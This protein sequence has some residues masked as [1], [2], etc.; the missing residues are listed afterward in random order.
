[1]SKEK[2]SLKSVTEQITFTFSQLTLDNVPFCHKTL[3][4]KMHFSMNN[5]A[6]DPTPVDNFIVQ[7]SKV[8]ELTRPITKD[9]LGH[10]TS[11]IIDVYV[12]THTVKGSGKEE[13]ATGKFDLSNLVR[14]GAKTF[15][16]PLTSSVLE[17][18]LHFNVDIKGGKDFFDKQFDLQNQE[19]APLP[20]IIVSS[21]K[22][23]FV[24]HHNQDTIES[25]AIHL[26]DVSMNQAQSGK[27]EQ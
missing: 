22:S 17:S 23:W 10:L 14:T 24:F 5:F 19:L 12:Y 20:K 27:T 3:S 15:D 21:K 16:L 4:I 2:K 11:S 18:S 13:I 1:M 25:D 6:T 8:I 7:W 26:A 9:T